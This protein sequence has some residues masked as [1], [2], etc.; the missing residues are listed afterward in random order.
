MTQK[1]KPFDHSAE[2]PLGQSLLD[3]W[4]R[5]RRDLPWRAPA[6]LRA[7]PYAV[8]LSEIM[9]QQT[10]VATVKGYFTSF[11]RRWPTVEH[12][13]AAPLE[14][15]LAE[16]A[17]LGYYAR[18]RNLHACAITVAR[19]HGGRFPRGAAAL[20]E[21][22]GVGAYTAA[23]IA[24]IAYEEPCVAVDGNVE[25]VISRLYALREPRQALKREVERRAA[26]LMPRARA[27]DFAQA[28]MDLGATLCRPRSP[29]CDRCPWCWACE[30]RH[31][32]RADDYPAKAA[33]TAKPHRRGAAFVLLK[34]DDVLLLRRPSAGLLGGMT[35]FPTT[36]LAEDVDPEAQLAHA[37]LAARWRRLDG[38]VR[39]VF[40][41][42]SLELAVFVASGG[43]EAKG[44]WASTATLHEQALPTL[45][46]KVAVHAGLIAAQ[47]RGAEK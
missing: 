3:W 23:A 30:A 40:T 2:P 31:A 35:G 25:R 24:A 22:P 32:G 7:D 27:G 15:V 21:L 14:D 19:R 37:P 8:W 16:W 46:R 28:M 47:R 34:G 13:A 29:E 44:I 33:K 39:H 20:R 6:G 45:M 36:P 18:A 9:L 12:L 43:A 41:H 11:L 5:E 17:G 10:T 1:S 42:F 26:L 4:D 38:A